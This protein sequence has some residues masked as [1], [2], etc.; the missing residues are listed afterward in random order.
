MAYVVLFFGA[1]K[2]LIIGVD[3]GLFGRSFDGRL[4]PDELLLHFPGQVPNGLAVTP[5]LLSPEYSGDGIVVPRLQADLFRVVRGEVARHSEAVAPV[6][7]DVLGDL[8]GLVHVL[9]H[10]HHQR[11]H[12]SLHGGIEDDGEDVEHGSA[13]SPDDVQGQP[14]VLHRHL[15][16][17][18]PADGRVQLEE[19]PGSVANHVIHG[20]ESH[21]RKVVLGLPVVEELHWIDGDSERAVADE[22]EGHKGRGHEKAE[23]EDLPLPVNLLVGR[24]EEVADGRRQDDRHAVRARVDEDAEGVE[25]EAFV[26]DAAE[27]EPQD[28][29]RREHGAEVRGEG[30]EG[31]QA[32][33]GAGEP[34]PQVGDR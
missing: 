32:N 14:V 13:G 6:L 31:S 16:G 4:L 8:L 25:R 18:R 33:V 3:E 19:P 9:E 15:D 27:V 29:L 2:T 10:G 21:H 24:H 11:P 20:Q 34:L 12:R 23:G 1:A 28:Q 22:E 26:D 7:V 17:H 30:E 5:L